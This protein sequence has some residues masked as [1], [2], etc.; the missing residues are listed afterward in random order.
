MWSPVWN[1]GDSVHNYYTRVCAHTSRK[2]G[3]PSSLCPQ[4]DWSFRCSWCLQ[5]V[6]S[7]LRAPDELLWD[8]SRA[9]NCCA[10]FSSLPSEVDSICLIN[11]LRDFIRSCLCI[12][13]RFVCWRW[14]VL[15]LP[16]PNSHVLWSRSCL[17]SNYF[18]TMAIYLLIEI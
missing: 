13:L 1:V 11:T 10:L 12:S 18:S 3:L 9:W 2:T 8:L 4:D 16:I 15:F 6:G 14:L 5:A 17:R 7:V